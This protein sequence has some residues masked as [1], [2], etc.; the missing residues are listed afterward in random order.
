LDSDALEVSP[1]H[2]IALYESVFTYLLTYGWW[3]GSVVKTSVC[4]WRTFPDLRMIYG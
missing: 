1:F 2:G 4:G 3:R